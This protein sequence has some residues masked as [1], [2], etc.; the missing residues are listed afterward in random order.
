MFLSVQQFFHLLQHQRRSVPSLQKEVK[1]HIIQPSHPPH[2]IKTTNNNQQQRKN[3]NKE[4]EKENQKHYL[5]D[6]CW[7]HVPKEFSQFLQNL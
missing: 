2:H 6:Q 4:R 5:E 3:K 1:Q 7:R